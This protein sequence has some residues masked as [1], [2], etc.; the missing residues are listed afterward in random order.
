[1][2][3]SRRQIVSFTFFRATPGWRLLPRTE[4]SE[5]RHEFSDVVTRWNTCG[6]MRVVPYSTIGTRADCDMMLWRICY[7]LEELQRMTADLLATRLGAHLAITHSLLGMTK[8]SR[9]MITHEQ[10]KQIDMRAIR[11]GE[12]KYLNISPLVKTAAWYNLDPDQRQMIINDQIRA[13]G[14]YPHVK[15]NIIYS[16][17]LDS[18]DFILAWESDS[19]EDLLDVAQAMRETDSNRYNQRDTPMFTC[20]QTSVD[21]MLERL[22]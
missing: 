10:H 21:E 7:T 18:Q 2:P 8:R 14:E 12:H 4:R 11:P 17:G 15:L 5:H 6:S 1:M 3:E 9:Y 19:P 16:F 22:G 20:V 13:L